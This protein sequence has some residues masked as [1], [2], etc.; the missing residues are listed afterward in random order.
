MLIFYTL[1]QLKIHKSGSCLFYS[2]LEVRY[3]QGIQGANVLESNPK[4]GA[5]LLGLLYSLREELGVSE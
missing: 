4:P 5:G 1:L 3:L 2:N